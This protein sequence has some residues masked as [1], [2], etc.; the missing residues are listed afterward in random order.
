MISNHFLY[1][2][3]VHHPI[4]TTILKWLFGVP[5]I[6]TQML[7]FFG[8][9]PKTNM[10]ILEHPPFED[11]FSWFIKWNMGGFV[12]VMLVFGGVYLPTFGNFYGKCIWD[13]FK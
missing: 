9:F 2:D 8:T 11:S 12:N 7:H 3:L 10:T 4:E 6:Y 1:K 5:G 13:I